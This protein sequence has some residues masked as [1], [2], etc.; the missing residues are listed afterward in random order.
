MNHNFT[1]IMK[2]EILYEPSSIYCDNHF[3]NYNV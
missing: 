1:E 3:D 2:N